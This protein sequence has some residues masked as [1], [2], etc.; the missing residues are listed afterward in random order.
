MQIISLITFNSNKGSS[1]EDRHPAVQT[2]KIWYRRTLTPMEA[3]LLVKIL[4]PRTKAVRS[5][6]LCNKDSS[7]VR[8]WP[9]R[10]ANISRSYLL[11]IWRNQNCHQV[12]HTIIIS[13]GKKSPQLAPLELHQNLSLVSLKTVL[14]L[15]VVNQAHNIKSHIHPQ[16]KFIF[17]NQASQENEL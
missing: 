6:I 14:V 1:L 15:V 2:T 12:P 13:P 5:S 17:H 9:H 7:V 11:V 16:N 3:Q 10:V 8:R 4:Q